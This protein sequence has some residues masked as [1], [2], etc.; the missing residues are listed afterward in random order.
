MPAEINILKMCVYNHW[1]AFVE[2]FTEECYV[3]DDGEVTCRGC[4]PEYTGRRCSQ[5]APG[6]EGNPLVAGEVCRPSNLLIF[7]SV[8]LAVY[9]CEL[10]YSRIEIKLDNIDYT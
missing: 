5:C 7:L 4:P 1:D 10:C 3:D 9:F 8:N 6:Y 2:R